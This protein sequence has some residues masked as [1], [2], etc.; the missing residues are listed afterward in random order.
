LI[1][2]GPFAVGGTVYP[3][4]HEPN[5][6]VGTGAGSLSVRITDNNGT[7][8]NMPVDNLGSFFLDGAANVVAPYGAQVVSS[9]GAM[10]AMMTKQTSLDCNSCHTVDGANGAP[11]RIMSP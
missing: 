7:V 5:D 2:G 10:R 6:C 9:S 1:E 3:T 11:G 4:A 8:F